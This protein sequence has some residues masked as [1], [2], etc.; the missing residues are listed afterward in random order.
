M[1]FCE[2]IIHEEKDSRSFS[3]NYCNC[4][5]LLNPTVSIFAFTL[6]R[7]NFCE[8]NYLRK[9][10]QAFFNKKSKFIF[11]RPIDCNSYSY[12]ESAIPVFAMIFQF[13]DFR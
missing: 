3:L 10:K 8:R 6:H 9:K 12:S 1:K 4:S 5:F 2:K 13:S 11:S 7:E